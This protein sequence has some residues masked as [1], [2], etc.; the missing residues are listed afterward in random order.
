M[1]CVNFEPEASLRKHI[2]L[3]SV[4]PWF[5]WSSVYVFVSSGPNTE[6]SEN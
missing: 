5:G 2:A 3:S 1:T 6:P 4:L